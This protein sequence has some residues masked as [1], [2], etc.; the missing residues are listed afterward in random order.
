MGEQMSAEQRALFDEAVDGDIAAIDE[1]LAA[2]QATLPPRPEGEKKS[3]KRAAL[4]DRLPRRDVS[5]EPDNTTC[6]CGEAMRR[7]GEDVS[8][9]LD[10]TP[11]VFTVE[12]HVRGKWCVR[13]AARWFRR[14]CRHR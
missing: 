4:P 9:K 11:G 7:V 13:L 5:H 6:G 10:Y 1:Q 3:P 14:L 2:L 12:R 8:E